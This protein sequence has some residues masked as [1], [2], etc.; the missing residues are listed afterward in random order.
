MKPPVEKIIAISKKI[1]I[2]FFYVIIV[3]M[4]VIILV[5]GYIFI[6]SPKIKDI[7]GGGE[8][9]LEAKKREVGELKTYYDELSAMHKAYAEYSEDK[10]KTI[11]SILPADKDIPGIYVQLQEIAKE[12]NFIVE[13]IDLSDIAVADKGQDTENMGTENILDI[14]NVIGEEKN[15]DESQKQNEARMRV[16]ESLGIR[17]MNIFIIISGGNYQ[18]LKSF[19]GD[20]EKNLRLFDVHDISF[21]T[22]AQE[23][24]YTLNLRTYYYTQ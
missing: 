7:K 4:V 18:D 15:A 10:I 3:S 19:L 16:L 5:G 8:I 20:I 14:P 9:S 22:S 23:G 24:P 21:G 1:F 12:N 13:S 17:E 11:T 2:N 6:L